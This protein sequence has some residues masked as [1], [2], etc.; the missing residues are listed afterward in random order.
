MKWQTGQEVKGGQ[1]YR[2]IKGEVIGRTSH[3]PG[4]LWW[5]DRPTTLTAAETRNAID[6]AVNG[7]KLTKRETTMIQYMTDYAMGIETS[8]RPPVASPE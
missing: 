8:D 1:I 7:Q 6:K 3:L 4:S 5:R 2:N